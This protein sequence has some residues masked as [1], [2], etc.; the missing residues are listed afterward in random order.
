MPS[1]SQDNIYPTELTANQTEYFIENV[2]N[3]SMPHL[4]RVAK[5]RPKRQPL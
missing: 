1:A 3:K 5:G 4:Q 2:I